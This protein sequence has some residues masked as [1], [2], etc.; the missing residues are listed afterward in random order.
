MTNPKEATIVPVGDGTWRLFFEYARDGASRIGIA[1]S[2]S[3]S[4]PWTVQDNLFEARPAAWDSWHLSTGPILLSNPERPIM[5]Y[6]GASE[7]AIWRIGWIEFDAKFERVSA[8]CE[9]P[10]IVPHDRLNGETD[11]AFAAS[12]TDLGKHRCDLFYSVTDKD[13][14]RV[15]LAHD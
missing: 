2:D 6:N 12:C 5:F 10:L 4:G 3:V 8:R 9:D 13:M 7:K 14:Y 11:I 1:T 15:I